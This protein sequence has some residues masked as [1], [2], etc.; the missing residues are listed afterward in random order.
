M[1]KVYVQVNGEFLPD[2]IVIP[3]TI[4]WRDGRVWQIAKVIHTC[5]ASDG[6]FEVI[7][8]TVLIGSAEKYLYQHGSR[9][10]V[11]SC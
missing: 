5:S 11:D 1:G 3:K 6:E 7:R 4:T 10:Y 9:W 2:G 8:Y